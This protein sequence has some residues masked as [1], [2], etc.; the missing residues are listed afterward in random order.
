[1]KLSLLFS[2]IV[3]SLFFRRIYFSR[4]FKHF[5]LGFSL[6]WQFSNLVFFQKHKVGLE[7]EYSFEELKILR[8]VVYK[9]ITK[10][11]NIIKVGDTCY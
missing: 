9:K 11:G 1:M 7:E 6:V 4:L 8:E 2:N 10:E 3:G 5:M